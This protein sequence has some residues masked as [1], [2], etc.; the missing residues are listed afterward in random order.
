MAPRAR[1]ELATLRLTASVVISS[2]VAGAKLN[3]RALANCSKIQGVASSAFVS[4]FFAFCPGSPQLILRLYY[5]AEKGEFHLAAYP[6]RTERWKSLQRWAYIAVVLTAAHAI[7]YQHVEKHIPP[8]QL[9]LYT[10]LALVL[11]FQTGVA[12]KKSASN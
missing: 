7:A 9:V 6:Y 3:R 5:V 12:F 8:F 1:F 4:R 10:V 2:E 11:V